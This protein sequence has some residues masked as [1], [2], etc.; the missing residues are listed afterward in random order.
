MTFTPTRMPESAIPQYWG[1]IVHAGVIVIVV[2]VVTLLAMTHNID[3]ATVGN[4]YTGALGYAAAK[5]GTVAHRVFSA[6]AEKKPDPA[7]VVDATG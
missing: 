2:A 7:G 6:R 1:D 4:V 5:S 3:H